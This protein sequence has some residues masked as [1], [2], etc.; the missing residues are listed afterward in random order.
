MGPSKNDEQ[1]PSAPGKKSADILPMEFVSLAG[2]MRTGRN[3]SPSPELQGCFK[4][5]TTTVRVF[6]GY[7]PSSTGNPPRERPRRRGM[8]RTNPGHQRIA[9]I[10]LRKEAS[11]RSPS[12]RRMRFLRK[13]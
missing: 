10:R 4:K 9:R 2:D 8:R 7:G 12:R 3:H 11:E 13:K 1:R 5:F 6:H